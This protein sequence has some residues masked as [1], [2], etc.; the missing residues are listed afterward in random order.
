MLLALVVIGNRRSRG[1]RASAGMM[2]GL[3]SSNINSRN[4]VRTAGR[5]FIKVQKRAFKWG[6]E[7]EATVKAG[8]ETPGH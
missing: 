3:Q 5:R 6:G 2:R 1:C 8:D 4:D 7:G